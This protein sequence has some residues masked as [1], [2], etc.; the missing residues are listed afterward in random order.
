M[1]KNQYSKTL[2]EELLKRIPQLEFSS[3]DIPGDDGTKADY[4]LTHQI[5]SDCI[6]ELK[7]HQVSQET[8][9]Q[10]SL[11]QVIEKT[12]KGIIPTTSFNCFL[13]ES[14]ESRDRTIIRALLPKFKTFLNYIAPKI[15]TPCRIVFPRDSI[16][17]P[18]GYIRAEV[19]DENGDKVRE[20]LSPRT[21]SGKVPIGNNHFDGR[22]GFKNLCRVQINEGKVATI[23]ESEVFSYKANDFYLELYSADKLLGGHILGPTCG[24]WSTETARIRDAIGKARRQLKN[25]DTEMCATGVI[26]CPSP[27]SP[28]DF[29][30]LEEALFGD[31]AVTFSIGPDEKGDWNNARD[32]HSGGRM[33]QPNMNTSISFVGF[34][35]KE[36]SESKL[37][38]IHNEFA[39][40]K[41]PFDY[42]NTKHISQFV[43]QFSK[44]RDGIYSQKVEIT[45][46]QQLEMIRKQNMIFIRALK[47]AR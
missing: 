35:S 10:L 40:T 3:L 9:D 30:N 47:A 18:L 8:Q 7:E 29:D 14:V 44:R 25:Y 17:Q 16:F 33:F 20:E 31:R 39:K 21:K 22:G 32:I 11:T 41:L 19:L 36:E 26:I 2:L 4:R 28:A 45:T 23:Q 12:F 34:L 43:Q 27:F 15:S 13:G 38:L 24:G 1:L 37:K 42:L 5:F 6:L 46:S